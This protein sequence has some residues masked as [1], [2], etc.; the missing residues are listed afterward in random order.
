MCSHRIL[1]LGSWSH[2]TYLSIIRFP[3]RTGSYEIVLLCNVLLPAEK[4]EFVASLNHTV[5]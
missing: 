5:Q 3:W 4:W 2:L 1:G